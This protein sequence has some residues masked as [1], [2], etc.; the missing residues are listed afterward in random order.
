MLY[1]KDTKDGYYQFYDGAD[2]RL[3]AG[4]I[5]TIRQL[6]T[7]EDVQAGINATAKEA[8]VI[9]DAQSVRSMREFILAKFTGDLLLPVELAAHNADS[10]RE[11]G[12]IK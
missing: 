1:F 12:K 2:P 6:P 3:Y 10:V 7:A 9:I 8:L 11:R 5:P 4:L